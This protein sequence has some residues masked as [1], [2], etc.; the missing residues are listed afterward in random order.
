[1]SL[2]AIW[3]CLNLMEFCTVT[4]GTL[5]ILSR[6]KI[7]CINQTLVT[8]CFC[9]CRVEQLL[10]N[11]LT[12][13]R[14][15]ATFL[16]LDCGVTVAPKNWEKLCGNSDEPLIYLKIITTLSKSWKSLT[17]IGTCNWFANLYSIMLTRDRLT[18]L[19]EVG[20]KIVKNGKSSG[21]G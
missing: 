6:W 12:N 20:R 8:Q 17:K 9:L 10:L 15:I 4:V 3:I 1:M 19:E 14:F 2:F 13:N 18:K 21:K 16:E 5:S 11:T 7:R